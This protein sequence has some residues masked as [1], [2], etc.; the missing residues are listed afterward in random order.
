MP[1]KLNPLSLTLQAGLY[2][3]VVREQTSLL[4]AY[5]KFLLCLNLTTGPANGKP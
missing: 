5:Q 4:H 3:P 2:R 1:I